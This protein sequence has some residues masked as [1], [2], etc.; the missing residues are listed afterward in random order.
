MPNFATVEKTPGPRKHYDLV[1]IQAQH[2]IARYEASVRRKYS[3]IS[4]RKCRIASF[5][6]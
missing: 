1:I 6:H 3:P 5:C 2:M 4:I